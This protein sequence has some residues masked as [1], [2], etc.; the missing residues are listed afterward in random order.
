M[1]K[2]L[3]PICAIALVAALSAACE[4][5][6]R[7]VNP[8]TQSRIQA[9]LQ[10]ADTTTVTSLILGDT[11]HLSRSTIEFYRNR[12]YRSAWVTD[13][14][15][16]EQGER[17]VKALSLTE[18][19]GLSPLRYRYDVI[20]KMVDTLRI[21][22]GAS[23]GEVDDKTEGV[24]AADV[25][26]L[27]T[28]GFARYALDLAQG[29]VYPDS[30]N[31]DWNIPRG[32]LGKAGILRALLRNADPSE[33][34]RRI[35][36]R[37]PQY[38]RLANV[39]VKLH[40]VRERGGWPAVPEGKIARGDSSVVVAALRARL[41]ASEDAREATYAQRGNTRPN[42]FDQDLFLALQHFQDRHAIEPDGSLGPQTLDELNHPVE[43]R[44]GEVKI[45]LDRWR[46]LPHDLGRMYVLVNVAGFELSVIENNRPIEEM[47]V[48]VG[49]EG[50]ETPI[51]ADTLERL[52]VNPSWNVPPSILNEEL[53]NLAED[54]SYLERNNFVRTSD[55]GLR[56]LPG[57]KNAL[58]EFKFEFPNKDN[59]YLHDTP[60]NALFSRASRAFS[61]GCIRLERPRDLAYLL[62]SKLARKTPRQIDRLAETGDTH[63]VNFRRK[64]P[65]YILYFTI[66]VDDDN[67]VRFHHDV[68]GHDES[69]QEQTKKFD[70][71]AT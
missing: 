57:P 17:I 12:G 32:S 52:I 40:E 22:G 34:V 59:I 38:I 67:T 49:Q 19:D 55:G 58:G 48:V 36:P 4:K 24:Y 6:A 30:A 11:L 64:I 31:L 69:L 51:F 33:L 62:A 5:E 14:D 10:K 43:D 37:T 27:L 9:L 8:G 54:P 1:K 47:N 20:R 3:R 7:K 2:L 18:A 66:W 44:I 28:E 39:L 16:T 70:S 53:A 23:K 56:Q 41:A 61:H 60:A 46:Y 13:D 71:R 65:I 21:E 25:D 26:L 35:R 29:T 63:T 68:Y 42:V 45:N 50:W 15:V